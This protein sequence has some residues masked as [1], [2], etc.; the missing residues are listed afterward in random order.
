VLRGSTSYDGKELDT[1]GCYYIP[2][3]LSTK[4]IQSPNGAELLVFTIPMYARAAWE[5]QA[6]EHGQERATVAA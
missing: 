2:E 6:R 5:R 1:F 3:G 4:P